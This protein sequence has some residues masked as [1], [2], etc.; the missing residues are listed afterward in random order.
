MYLLGTYEPKDGSTPSFWETG[1]LC[2]T[3]IVIVVNIKV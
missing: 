3:A 1:A 2:F